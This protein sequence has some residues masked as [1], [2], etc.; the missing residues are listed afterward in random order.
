MEIQLGQHL[1]DLKR[2]MKQH[3][4]DFL[5][6]MRAVWKLRTPA[7]PITDDSARSDG[8]KTTEDQPVSSEKLKELAHSAIDHTREE[9]GS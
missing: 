1:H 6:K 5:A 9:S 4:G 8:G 3:F 2:S 7:G